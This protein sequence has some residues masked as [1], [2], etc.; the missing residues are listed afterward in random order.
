MLA[1]AAHGT[2]PFNRR[3]AV[4]FESC[5]ESYGT[6]DPDQEYMY[7]RQIGFIVLGPSPVRGFSRRYANCRESGPRFY[8]LT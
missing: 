3:T 6:G 8:R 1:N 4:R 7:L 5:D 2:E